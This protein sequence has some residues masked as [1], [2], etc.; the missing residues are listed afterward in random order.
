MNQITIS[1]NVTR[2]VELKYTPSGKAV[3]SF[4][5]AVTRGKL[6]DGTWQSDFFNC[7]AWDNLA[8]NVAESATKGTKVMVTGKLIVD[9]HTDKE[10]V[11]KQY[12]KINASEVGIDLSFARAVVMKNEKA[13]PEQTTYNK[14]TPTTEAALFD[15]D[16]VPF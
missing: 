13:T 5:V 7:Q 15:D 1:G 12:Y 8:I 6:P 14:T 16:D 2:D 3:A 11:N 9:K 4:S 10:G